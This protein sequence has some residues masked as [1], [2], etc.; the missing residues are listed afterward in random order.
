[1]STTDLTDESFAPINPDEEFIRIIFNPEHVNED[2]QIKPSA[3]PSQ[4]LSESDRGYSIDRKLYVKKSY[5][6]MNIEQYLKRSISRTLHGLALIKHED[7]L[8][9]RDHANQQALFVKPAPVPNN[10]AHALILCRN[11]YSPAI[12]KKLRNDLIEKFQVFQRLED[13]FT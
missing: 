1:M 9:I 5:I 4:D 6:E 2:G 13:I 11:P 3:V 7:I 8:N 10:E 12:I